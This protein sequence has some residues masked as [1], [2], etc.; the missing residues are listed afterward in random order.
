ML[1]KALEIHL[2]P[3]GINGGGKIPKEGDAARADTGIQ[4]HNCLFVRTHV[5]P[6][7]VLMP[8]LVV[9]V[10]E[11][12]LVFTALGRSLTRCPGCQYEL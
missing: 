10:T 7:S 5:W 4:Y 1:L 12:K 3:A 2:G 8:W 11:L 6:S 9:R